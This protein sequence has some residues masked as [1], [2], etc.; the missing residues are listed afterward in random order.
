MAI[1]ADAARHAHQRAINARKAM[2]LACPDGNGILPAQV[3]FVRVV[4]RAAELYLI[5]KTATAEQQGKSQY[6]TT[7]H[8][9]LF[10]YRLPSVDA[11]NDRVLGF[12]S[13]SLGTKHQ[14]C[15]RRVPCR[16]AIF[17]DAPRKSAHE[18][19]CDEARANALRA[20]EVHAQHVRQRYV[21][22]RGRT[23]RV[24]LVDAVEAESLT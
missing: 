5:E 20:L 21:K 8:T 16:D 19:H 6:G 14:P 4:A 7:A 2:R 10:V 1:E 18:T 22:R 17:P 11:K 3:D 13:I 23:P 12:Q 15:Q 9:I 24:R